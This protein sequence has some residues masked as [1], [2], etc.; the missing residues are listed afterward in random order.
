MQPQFFHVLEN[1]DEMAD[2][3]GIHLL[4]VATWFRGGGQ[5]TKRFT[6]LPRVTRPSAATREQK[7]TLL[8]CLW[9][10]SVSTAREPGTGLEKYKPSTTHSQRYKWSAN[11]AFLF[12]CFRMVIVI[13]FLSFIWMK[14]CFVFVKTILNLIFFKEK[15]ASTSK[16]SL[17]E[18]L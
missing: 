15:K 12:F 3:K 13:E 5:V 17:R 2:W 8:A 18:L 16:I 11:L 14:E 10:D 7:Q 4:H 6:D 9:C 1:Q